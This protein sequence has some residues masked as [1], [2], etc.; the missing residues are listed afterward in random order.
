[1]EHEKYEIQI[2]VSLKEAL[3]AHNRIHWLY[4]ICG[5]FSIYNMEVE[6]FQKRPDDPQEPQIFN[7]GPFIK[8]KCAGPDTLG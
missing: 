1:M 6:Y 3:F 4:I 7:I 2:S 5:W 8:K